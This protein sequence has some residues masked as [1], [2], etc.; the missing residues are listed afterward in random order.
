MEKWIEQLI[1]KTIIS[2]ISTEAVA[3]VVDYLPTKFKA[4]N[5]NPCTTKK[6]KNKTPENHSQLLLDRKLISR[7]YNDL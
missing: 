5:S 4:L 2:S 6:E 3:Q 7:I 1:L